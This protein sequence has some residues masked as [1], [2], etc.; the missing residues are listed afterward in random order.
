MT[1]KDEET[2]VTGQ[3]EQMI[4]L[5]DLIRSSLGSGVPRAAV[6]ELRDDIQSLT[7]AV[8]ILSRILKRRSAKKAASA[9]VVET[10]KPTPKKKLSQSA[11]R[12][13]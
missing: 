8:Q 7:S 12:D 3:L 1:V 10:I 9:P 11:T 13:G 5:L 6:P 4:K 2:L